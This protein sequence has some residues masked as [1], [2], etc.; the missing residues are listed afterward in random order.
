MFVESTLSAMERVGFEQDLAGKGLC[1]GYSEYRR[2]RPLN[3]KKCYVGNI[4]CLHR[5]SHVVRCKFLNVVLK[6]H[7]L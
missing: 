3:A 6:L 7:N 5:T 1:T 2:W 4:L